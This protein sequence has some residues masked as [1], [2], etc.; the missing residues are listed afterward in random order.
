LIPDPYLSFFRNKCTIHVHSARVP[1]TEA[2]ASA[3]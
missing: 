1:R 2:M 3:H